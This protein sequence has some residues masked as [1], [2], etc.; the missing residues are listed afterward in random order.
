MLLVVHTHLDF[1]ENELDSVLVEITEHRL[2]TVSV[3]MGLESYEQNKKIAAGSSLIVP[4]FGVHPWK[5]HE[6]A[7]N[8]KNV[9]AAPDETPMFGEIGLDYHWVEKEHHSAEKEVF[10]FFLG[11]AKE[12]DKIVN[13]HTKDAEKEVLEYLKGYNIE[14]A[15]IHWY[16]GPLNILK[17]LLDNGVYFTAGVE[18]LYTEHIQNI[19]QMIPNSQLLTETDN[20]GG[21][22][23]ISGSM[24]MPVI[25]KDVL[26]K[27]SE[28]RKTTPEKIEEI[29]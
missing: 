7:G 15:I 28:L 16:S 4:C 20:P 12:R 19:A 8:L 27:F 3:A 17:K 14:R 11:A 13:F 21:M 23:Y 24:G 22:E 18:I 1:Y 25:I 9:T 10:E 5:A 2:F 29:V 6:N 26:S